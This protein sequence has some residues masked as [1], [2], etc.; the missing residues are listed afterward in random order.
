M[1]LLYYTVN[2]FKC[3]PFI[4]T[5]LEGVEISLISFQYAIEAEYMQCFWNLYQTKYRFTLRWSNTCKMPS[6]KETSTMLKKSWDE[7]LN[8]KKKFKSILKDFIT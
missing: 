4:L 3:K 7:N 8:A 5:G 2:L 1:V 6:I